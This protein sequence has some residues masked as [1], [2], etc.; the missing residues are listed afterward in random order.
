L[1]VQL[2]ANVEEMKQLVQAEPAL[3]AIEEAQAEV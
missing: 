1:G 2:S 3:D